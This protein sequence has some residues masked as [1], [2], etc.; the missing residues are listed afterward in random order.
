MTLLTAIKNWFADTFFKV[1]VGNADGIPLPHNEMFDG[2]KE[3]DKPALVDKAV[4]QQATI[5]TLKNDVLK[6]KAIA[7][8]L[9]VSEKLDKEHFIITRN[10]DLEKQPEKLL[11][12]RVLYEKLTHEEPKYLDITGAIAVWTRCL[13]KDSPGKMVVWSP[14]TVQSKVLFDKDGN[15]QERVLMAKD[16]SLMKENTFLPVGISAVPN[17]EVKSIR[18][19]DGL[20]PKK[21][22][23]IETEEGQS[24]SP[25]SF[26]DYV[27]MT[28]KFENK[29]EDDLDKERLDLLL[30]QC[31]EP[32]RRKVMSGLCEEEI[33]ELVCVQNAEHLAKELLLRRFK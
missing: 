26:N 14:N 18:V 30:A 25:L 27:T 20:N 6:Y 22:E 28:N 12:E 33:L 31:S 10:G 29:L 5:E 11:V 3:S 19:D 24:M 2:P 17:S 23:F 15:L 8:G 9:V 13:Q 21:T 7:S 16:D 32:F 4:E 1:A